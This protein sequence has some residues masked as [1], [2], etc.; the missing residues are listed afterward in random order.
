VLGGR[1]VE[2]RY[3]GNFMGQPFS[4]LGYTGYDNYRKKYIGSWM[5]P[6]P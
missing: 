6:P 2:Q 3:A 1:F 5:D 4:G